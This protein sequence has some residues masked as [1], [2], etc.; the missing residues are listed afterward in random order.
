VSG[1]SE[2]QPDIGRGVLV[3]VN[4]ELRLRLTQRTRDAKVGRRQDRVLLGAYAIKNG[5]AVG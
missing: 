2:A 3:T 5:N 1:K 4:I